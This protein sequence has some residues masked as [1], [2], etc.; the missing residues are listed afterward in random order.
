[1]R[2]S[3]LLRTWLPAAPV[4]AALAFGV[5]SACSVNVPQQSVYVPPSP[6]ATGS[7]YP[8]GEGFIGRS[9]PCPSVDAGVLLAPDGRVFA[10]GTWRYVAD[11]QV[12]ETESGA[13]FSARCE[14][15]PTSAVPIPCPTPAGEGSLYWNDGTTY[16]AGQWDY[17]WARNLY[18]SYDGKTAPS[19]NGIGFAAVWSPFEVERLDDGSLKLV[20]GTI[21][22]PGRYK[23]LGNGLYQADWGTYYL[24]QGTMSQARPSIAPLPPASWRQGH[25]DPSPSASPSAPPVPW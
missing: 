4:L 22:V 12:Y 10:R 3:P 13:V 18:A 17:L 15:T 7:A 11:R 5:V 20:D 21:L 19:C 9:L 6:Q 24:G 16:P 8:L 14:V 23:D 1:M 25:F 2:H